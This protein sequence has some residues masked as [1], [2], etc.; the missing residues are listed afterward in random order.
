MSQKTTLETNEADKVKA[1]KAKAKADRLQL[2]HS[3]SSFYIDHKLFRRKN[4]ATLLDHVID[5]T[6]ARKS[7]LVPGKNLPSYLRALYDVPLLPHIAEAPQF[8]KM[9]YA[10]YKAVTLRQQLRKNSNLKAIAEVETYFRLALKVRD[11][12]IRRNMRLVVHMAK[13]WSCHSPY[14]IDE[15]IC[16]GNLALIR[17]VDKFDVRKGFRFSTYATGGIIHMFLNSYKTY[18]RLITHELGIAD[19]LLADIGVD[20]HDDIGDADH[21]IMMNGAFEIINPA[22]QQLGPREQEIIALRYGLKTGESSTLAETGEIMGVTKERIRQIQAS[23]LEK[24]TTAVNGMK[25]PGRVA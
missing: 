3:Y 21:K 17:C 23:A 7:R 20:Q 16:D 22:L 19:E 2:L 1:A 8:L 25:W 24:L 14:T 10:K 11:E 13:K 12:L 18:S 6:N 9:N 4:A 15:L 5:D